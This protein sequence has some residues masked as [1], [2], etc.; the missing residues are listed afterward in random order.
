MG[1]GQL[2]LDF[3]PIAE[4]LLDVVSVINLSL[5]LTSPEC[6]ISSDPWVLKWVL[7]LLLP[8]WTVCVLVVVGGVFAVLIKFRVGWLGGK[9][10]GQLQSSAGRS[11][12]QLL[13]LLYLP[14]TSVAFAPFGCQKDATGRWLMDADPARSC[15]TSSWWRGLFPV[16]L[17]AV[18]AYAVAILARAFLVIACF[19][20]MAGD[21]NKANAAV[22]AL[23][24]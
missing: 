16:G 3:G 20:F 5:E 18:L 23:V 12:F 24:V 6:S 15:Y 8:L 21:E 22:L 14:L 2:N 7:T 10:M 1:Y 9:T 11:F 4:R 17:A 19:T 13:V